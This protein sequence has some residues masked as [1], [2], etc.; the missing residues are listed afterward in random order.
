MRLEPVTSPKNERNEHY[1]GGAKQSEQS[2]S[3]VHM[4]GTSTAL[5]Q[6]A[7][8]DVYLSKTHPDFKALF[9]T[10]N[11]AYHQEYKLCKRA[12]LVQK[13]FWKKNNMKMMVRISIKA[14]LSERYTNHCIRGFS[15]GSPR[16]RFWRA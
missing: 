11:K 6:V 12:T 10:S 3:D 9:Q 15:Y 13:S 4:Y 2:Y 7:A 8:F 5:D 14:E 1:Q 16:P